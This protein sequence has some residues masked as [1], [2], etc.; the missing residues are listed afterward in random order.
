MLFVDNGESETSLIRSVF[1]L[2]K[3]DLFKEV[4][5]RIS[6]C[7]SERHFSYFAKTQIIWDGSIVTLIAF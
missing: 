2:G 6:V 7:I 1:E 4:T 5:D 3:G